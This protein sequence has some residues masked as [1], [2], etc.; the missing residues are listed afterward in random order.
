VLLSFRAIVAS[1][2]PSVDTTESAMLH[3]HSKFGHFPMRLT[4]RKTCRRP[5][6]QGAG[7]VC[8]LTLLVC[9]R[10]NVAVQAQPMA[11]TLADLE[12]IA[13]QNN[14]TLVMASAQVAAARGR[15]VQAG[16]Y[17]NPMLGYSGM[18]MGDDDTAGMQGGFVNQQFITGG[19]LRLDRAVAGQEIRE[20]RYLYDVQSLRVLSD[21]RLRFYQSLV[22]QRR[23]ELTDQLRALSQELVQ[24]S[25]QLLE[26]RQL[27]END[28]LQAEIESQETELLTISSRNQLNEAWQRLVAVIGMPMLE[29]RPLVG[30]L[31]SNLPHY[32]WQQCTHA[33]MTGNPELAAAW[34]RVHRAR[35]AI[36]RA[37][38]ENI[39]NIDVMASVHHMN[40]NG[41]D[42]AGVQVGMPIPILNRNQGN[43]MAAEAELV[44][45]C[46]D[47]RRIELALQDG[48]AVAFRGYADARQQSDLY[49]NEILPRAQRSLDLVTRGYGEGQVDYLTLL[50][51][52]R[53]YIRVNLSYLDRLGELWRTMISIDG[54]L[55]TDGLKTP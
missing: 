20:S 12:Q 50:T 28:L 7:C 5:K 29:M 43:I 4:T 13:A 15:Q 49:R 10:L 34:A 9:G 23:M 40:T 3:Y 48:L 16:L 25:Q 41:D 2:G 52:Q 55:L 31:D 27:S 36:Q 32:D 24:S 30:D 1:S 53:T 19:K 54:K 33:V 22:A 11:L 44:E 26:G 46:N 14:P 37:R 51:S 18:E 6:L 17:P 21:V 42:V 8:L 38:R 45:A 39:P 35:L 47:V